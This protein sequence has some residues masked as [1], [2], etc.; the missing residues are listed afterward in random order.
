MRIPLLAAARLATALVVALSGCSAHTSTASSSTA[1]PAAD[2]SA[3][4]IKASDITQPADF[5]TNAPPTGFTGGAP[6]VNPNGK[7]GVAGMFKSQDASRQ[8]NDTV[9]VLADDS[10]AKSALETAVAG[11]GSLVSIPNPQ[12]FSPG[13]NGTMFSGSS[14]DQSKTVAVVMFTRG[15]AFATLEFDGAPNDPV[16]V[17]FINDVGQKQDAA[18]KAGLPSAEVRAT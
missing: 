9:V 4:L 13:E 14:P 3:L 8:I 12:S 16:D 18:I 17:G 2:Y 1:S 10:A 6:T 7:P 15:K 11:I 5:F